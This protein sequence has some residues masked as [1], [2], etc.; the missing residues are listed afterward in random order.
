MTKGI[1]PHAPKPREIYRHLPSGTYVLVLHVEGTRVRHMTIT[2]Q[3][4]RRTTT[5][6]ISKFHASIQGYGGQT[7]VSGY[8]LEGVLDE[9][10]LL[11]ASVHE[12][13]TDV[14]AEWAEKGKNP[15]NP[16]GPSTEN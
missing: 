9:S 15:T 14:I 4:M 10:S 8:V 1:E 3:R 16:E 13:L 11:P 5:T 2:G 7:R 6:D 12:K